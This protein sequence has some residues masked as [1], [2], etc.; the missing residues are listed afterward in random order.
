[1]SRLSSIVSA[2][3][4]TA[5]ATGFLR[6]AGESAVEVGST[7]L[8]DGSPRLQLVTDEQDVGRVTPGRFRVAFCVA[9]TGTGPLLL[10]AVSRRGEAPPITT[11]DAGRIGELV[12]EFRA[13]EL[14]SAG[15]REFV[16]HTN[17][18]EQPKLWLTVRGDVMDG[19][20][21]EAK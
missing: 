14:L 9:N 15:W 3:V 4:F 18:P 12:I 10:R 2:V 1:M 17:D 11:V 5:A 21:D 13:E 20:P 7:D 19:R 6:L 16:F 8:D